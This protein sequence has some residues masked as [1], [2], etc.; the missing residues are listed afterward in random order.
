MCIPCAAPAASGLGTL[1][2]ILLIVVASLGLAL[3]RAL[4][5]IGFTLGGIGLALYR[6]FSGSVLE[7]PLRMSDADYWDMAR[8]K[9]H[10]GPLVTRPVRAVTRTATV[11]VAVG[12]LTNWVVTLLILGTLTALTGGTA[13]YT[14]RDA[15]KAKVTRRAIEGHDDR[16]PIRVKARVGIER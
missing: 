11:A 1:L 8:A 3:W 5:I 12:L 13:A 15:I 4:P 16:E 9:G 6:F 10:R 7:K 14:R 2:L